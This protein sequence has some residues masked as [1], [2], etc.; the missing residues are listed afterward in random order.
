MDAKLQRRVQRYGWDLAARDYE[1]LWQAQLA[2]AQTALLAAA[3]LVPGERV[4]DVACGTGLVTFDAA[5]AVGPIGRVLGIDLSG[6]MVDAARRHAADR[7]AT[8]VDFARMDAEAL[9]LPDASVDV[10]LCALGLMYLPAPERALRELRRVL[11]PGGRLGIL[12][13][14]TPR[15]VLAPFYRLWFDRIVPLLGRVLPGGEAYTYLPASV[16]RFPPPEELASL[17]AANGFA[18]VRYRTFAGGIVAL[19]VGDAE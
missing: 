17:F 14:T 3:A 11:R 19:H 16:R 2:G 6:G 8:N 10:A 13:I 1:A 18:S 4:L 5:R 7:Q 9:A 15:G 12:E